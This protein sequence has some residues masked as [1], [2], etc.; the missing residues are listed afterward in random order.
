MFGFDPAMNELI[1]HIYQKY[2]KISVPFFRSR[3]VDALKKGRGHL[4][5]VTFGY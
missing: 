4:S 3:Y 1:L 5:L 2:K